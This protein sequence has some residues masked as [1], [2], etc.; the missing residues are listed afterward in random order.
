MYYL[1]L[2][3]FQR[4]VLA[5]TQLPP[6][7]WF[8]HIIQWSNATDTDHCSSSSNRYQWTCLICSIPQTHSARARCLP[9]STTL[10]KSLSPAQLQYLLSPSPSFHSIYACPFPNVYHACFMCIVLCEWRVNLIKYFLY[11][12]NTIGLIHVI[13]KIK[14]NTKQKYI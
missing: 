5:V 14:I 10:P 1:A 13:S 8:R 11:V 3:R 9:H 7:T 12:M 2:N 6:N 4:S